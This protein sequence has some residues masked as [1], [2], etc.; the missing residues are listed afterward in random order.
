MIRSPF[1]RRSGRNRRCCACRP[2]ML[3]T[4]R[5]SR[6]VSRK[7]TSKSCSR[8]WS[9]IACVSLQRSSE[10]HAIQ[11]QTLE[12][13]LDVV[14]RDTLRDTLRVESIGGLQAQQRL[15]R[16]ERRRNGD[17][18]I[19]ERHQIVLRESTT[20]RKRHQQRDQRRQQVSARQNLTPH[21]EHAQSQRCAHPDPPPRYPPHTNTPYQSPTHYPTT[22][23]PNTPYSHPDLSLI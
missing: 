10:T 21:R 4:R 15:F 19:L 9:W 17:R 1:R 6:R 20:T 14:F 12:Q 8:V 3:S 23:S 5:V 7:T 16:P 11:L 22:H 2:P 13:L 18:I